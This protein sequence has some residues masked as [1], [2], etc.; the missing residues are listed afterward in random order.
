M[1]RRR[2][3]PDGRFTVEATNSGA[4]LTGPDTSVELAS[5]QVKI[6]GKKVA[7]VSETSFDLTASTIREA[8]SATVDILASGVVHIKGSQVRTEQGP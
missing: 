1:S 5:G 2:P 7:V 6:T 4:R 8:A 3:S